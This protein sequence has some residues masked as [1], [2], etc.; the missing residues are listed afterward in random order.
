[1]YFDQNA[2]YHKC[3]NWIVAKLWFS[4][5]L[6]VTE[7]VWQ[8][9][10]NYDHIKNNMSYY[11]KSDQYGIDIRVWYCLKSKDWD[12]SLKI[13]TKVQNVI[14]TYGWFVSRHYCIEESS[15]AK[16]MKIMLTHCTW[17]KILRIR[18]WLFILRIWQMATH[19]FQNQSKYYH[20]LVDENNVDFSTMVV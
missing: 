1:M 16:I 7:K 11:R 3:Q 12:Y 6:I 14:V 15:L 13:F 4:L 10:S 8:I 19:L 17:I 5:G 20:P 2:I 9:R 18:T